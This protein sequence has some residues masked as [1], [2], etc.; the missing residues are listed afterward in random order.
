MLL[1]IMNSL[2]PLEIRSRILIDSV[3]QQL[4]LDWLDDC[5][6][7][8]YSSGSLTDIKTHHAAHG[9]D[10]D[11]DECDARS[12]LMLAH[13]QPANIC[14]ADEVT[15]VYSQ[16]LH[17]ADDIMYASNQHRCRLQTSTSKGCRCTAESTCR[18]HFSHE[19]Y[20]STHVDNDTG[21]IHFKKTEPWINTFNLVMFHALRCNTNITCLLSGMQVC[22]IIAY[23][24]DYVTKSPLQMHSIFESI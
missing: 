18:A 11:S 16:V 14:T 1:W 24:T 17:D 2:S 7:G 22:A 20:P 21:A 9:V 19:L 12:V 4:M 13:V 8:D 3:F 6:Q 5:Q 23:I 10:V 15:E